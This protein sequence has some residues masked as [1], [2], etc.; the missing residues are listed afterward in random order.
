MRHVHRFGGGRGFVEQGGVRNV[1]PGEIDD[2]LLEIHQ[3]FHAALGD[4]RLVRR[5]GGVPAGIL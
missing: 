3:R 5:V 2:H 4:L 1:E